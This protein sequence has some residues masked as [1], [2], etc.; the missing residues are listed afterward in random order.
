MA[1]DTYTPGQVTRLTLAVDDLLGAPGDPGSLVLKVRSPYG[2]I[3]VYTFG[4]DAEVVRDALGNYHA[5]LPL[6]DAGQWK[7]RWELATP[8]AGAAEGTITVHRS[9]LR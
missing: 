7:Y 2:V 8:N 1:E 6:P 4:V 9:Y 5:D 3:T